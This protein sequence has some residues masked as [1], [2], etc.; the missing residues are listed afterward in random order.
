MVINADTIYG[1]LIIKGIRGQKLKRIQSVVWIHPNGC[2][3]KGGEKL[4]KKLLPWQQP[5]SGMEHSSN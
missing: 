5:P 2:S 4:G 3:M 1:L